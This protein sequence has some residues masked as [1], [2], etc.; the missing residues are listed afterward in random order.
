MDA[1]PGPVYN[2]RHYTRGYS[3]ELIAGHVGECL[4]IFHELH[5]EYGIPPELAVAVYTS[6]QVMVAAVEPVKGTPA[7]PNTKPSLLVPETAV[8]PI[9][10]ALRGR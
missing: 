1:H 6:V 2:P 4:S 7:D 9:E 8:G 5:D 10:S 3:R